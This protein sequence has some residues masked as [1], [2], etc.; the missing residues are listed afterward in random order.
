MPVI[1]KIVANRSISK[2][3]LI[4]ARTASFDSFFDS[5]NSEVFVLLLSIGMSGACQ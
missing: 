2:L 3:I 1:S 4:R 5:I